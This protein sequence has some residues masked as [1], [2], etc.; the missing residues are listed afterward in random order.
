MATTG[1][2][3]GPQGYQAAERLPA[4][5]TRNRMGRGVDTWVQDCAPGSENGTVLD[6][7][8]FNT[9]IGNLRYLVKS[10]VDAGAGISLTDGDMTLLHQAVKYFADTA[11]NHSIDE[12]TGLQTALGSL[13]AKLDLHA[14]A[15]S[16]SY[17]DLDDKPDPASYATAAQGAKAD[18]AMLKADAAMPK[19]GGDFTG[20]VKA[21]AVSETLAALAG[22]TPDMDLSAATLFTLT[23]SSRMVDL[24]DRCGIDVLCGI[25]YV[26]TRLLALR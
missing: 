12:I 16:G 13:V 5:T 1:T 25:S 11:H 8:F 21:V 9:I 7:A 22:A 6:A 10:A 18:A 24:R 26:G 14:V 19:A 23:V 3:F 17:G 20:P 4:G 2:A 15:T